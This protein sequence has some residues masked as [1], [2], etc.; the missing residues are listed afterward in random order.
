MVDVGVYLQSNNAWVDQ[1][2]CCL[3]AITEAR[4]I[5]SRAGTK[6]MYN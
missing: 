5:M 2:V 1:H 3:H 4:L 6:A